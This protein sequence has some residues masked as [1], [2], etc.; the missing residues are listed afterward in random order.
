VASPLVSRL[1]LAIDMAA[2][3]CW[4]PWMPVSALGQPFR[5]PANTASSPWWRSISSGLQALGTLP[6][7][8]IRLPAVIS[9]FWSR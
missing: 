1:P 5:R 2:R 9:R 4:N 6:A 8:G 3:W 7:V